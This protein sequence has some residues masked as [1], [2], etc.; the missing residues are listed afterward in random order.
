MNEKKQKYEAIKIEV[1]EVENADVITTSSPIYSEH[2]NGYIDF[3][4]FL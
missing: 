1:R 4:F 3:N 2:D